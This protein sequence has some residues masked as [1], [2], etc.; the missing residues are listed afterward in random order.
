MIT[1]D[2][3]HKHYDTK[4]QKRI[5]LRDQSL[6]FQRGFSYGLLGVNGAGK[7]TTMRLLAG[8]ELPNRGT[9][10]RNARISWPLGFSNGFHPTMSGRENLKFVARAYGEDPATVLHFVREFAE[11]GNYIDEPIKN[12]SSGM[13]A[14]FA[15][16]LSMA[17]EFDCYLV[18]EITSVGDANFQKRCHAA[19]DARREFSDVV[20]IS[21]DMST[22][23]L[24][25]DKGLVLVDGTLHYFDDIE[26]AIQAYYRLN[27]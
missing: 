2:R 13:M 18:D 1:M 4:N 24:Y 23:S 6:Y 26:A 17:I 5:I 16:G 22:I 27:R 19:F 7:S 8:T 12:Y 14:R 9:I 21:H 11:I 25:C 10:S 20:M 15:F 3:V